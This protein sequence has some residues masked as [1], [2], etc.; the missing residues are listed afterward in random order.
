[1]TSRIARFGIASAAAALA[2]VMAA[3]TAMAYPPNPPAPQVVGEGVILVSQ[4][5][6][7]QATPRK[8]LQPADGQRVQVR[9]GSVVAMVVTNLVPNANYRVSIRIDGDWNALGRTTADRNGVAQLPAVR[10]ARVGSYPVRMIS[11]ADP[12]SPLSFTLVVRRR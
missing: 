8:L 9:R 12:D 10:I 11:A 1:M 5:T 6:A 3:P 7:N 2:L 4:Q